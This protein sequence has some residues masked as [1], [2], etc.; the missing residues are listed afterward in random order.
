[1]SQI[2]AGRWQVH[3]LGQGSGEAQQLQE[4]KTISFRDWDIGD[5]HEWGYLYTYIYHL[6]LFGF[7]YTL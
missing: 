3:Y 5:Y 6:Y 1:M 2:A 7:L 4:I